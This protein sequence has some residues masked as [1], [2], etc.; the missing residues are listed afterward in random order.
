MARCEIQFFLRIF[1]KVEAGFLYLTMPLNKITYKEPTCQCR[2]HKRHEFDPWVRKISE[3]LRRFPGEGNSNLLQYSCLENPTGRGAWWATVYGV[4]KSQT[5]LGLHS[6]REPCAWNVFWLR[7]CMISLNFT[8][9]LCILSTL[10]E[11]HRGNCVK[12]IVFIVRKFWKKH[13]S[14]SQG[15]F[16]SGKQQ[17]NKH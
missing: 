11:W 1:W 17:Q 6:S 15:V 9:M 14:M 5:W 12:H 4:S 8:M 13:E 10:R 16:W 2:K 3:D 7:E